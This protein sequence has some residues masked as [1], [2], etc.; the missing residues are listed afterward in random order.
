MNTPIAEN[1]NQ[2]D[3][4]APA[5]PPVP[6]QQEMPLA[7]VRGEPVLQL[8]QDVYIPP[9]ELEVIFDAFEGPLDL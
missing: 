8:P 2:H 7:L 5:F 1:Q 3:E 6:Q 9:D 4:S